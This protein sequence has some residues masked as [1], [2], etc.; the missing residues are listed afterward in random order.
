[1]LK[2]DTFLQQNSLILIVDP[3]DPIKL[4]G[5]HECMP[6]GRPGGKASV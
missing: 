6:A 3:I 5:Y 4:S 2:I 1:M